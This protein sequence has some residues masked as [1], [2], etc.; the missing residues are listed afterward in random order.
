MPTHVMIRPM[1]RWNGSGFWT[2]SVLPAVM[3]CGGES[4]ESGACGA[5]DACGG[6]PAGDWVS[7][8][9]CEEGDLDAILRESEAELPPACA[10]S[11]I[12]EGVSPNTTLNI[13][14]TGNFVEAGAIA[15]DWRISF[16]LPCISALAE[17]PVPAAS[18]PIFCQAFQ[19]EI[20][21]ST[22]APFQSV[23]CASSETSCDCDANQDVPVGV[24]GTFPEDGSNRN[25][26]VNGDELTRLG[27]SESDVAVTIT[28]TRQR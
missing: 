16:E 15:L 11:F 27:G 2:W 14:A 10:G 9:V 8:S 3:A 19:D 25:F 5:F 22:E 24:A 6:D 28:Y 23:T 1:P 26:C 20:S 17:Q 18:I 4:G 21:S 12:I 7:V 13:D